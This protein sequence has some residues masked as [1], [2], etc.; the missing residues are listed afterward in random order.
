MRSSS[1]VRAPGQELRFGISKN[2]Y[3]VALF[4]A[5]AAT[6]AVVAGVSAIY[7]PYDPWVVASPTFP[8]QLWLDAWVRWDSGW[9]RQ[10]AENGYFNIPGQQ[11][12]V[13]FF[14]AYPMLMRAGAFLWGSPVA[15]GIA[16]TV[17]SGLG[18]AIL[19]FR[20][21]RDRLDRQSARIALL[22]L[23]LWPF[24]FYLFGAVY[25]DALFLF[26][27][28]GAFVLLE[29]DRTVLA[30]LAAAVATATRPIGLAV[31]AGLWIRALERRGVP[32]EGRRAPTAGLKSLRPRDAGLLLSPLG[33]LFYSG[34]LWWRFGNPLAF[35]AG[36]G[37]PGW[38]QPLGPATWLKFTFFKVLSESPLLGPTQLRLLVHAGLTFVALSLVPL[39]FRRFGLGYGWYALLVLLIPAISSKDFVGMGRYALAAFPCFV[40]AGEI[41]ASR[42]VLRTAVLGVSATGLVLI[43]SRFARWYYVA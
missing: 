21:C 35:A 33:F 36:S 27:T 43:T 29:R 17:L 38:D 14:P 42:P 2:W 18:S 13:A 24:A 1:G 34:Y 37:A 30:G 12:S 9:Y 5:V 7:L 10:I 20:W 25:S 4:L 31:V 32:G 40:V 26:A 39:V 23:M 15:A 22:L 11:S 28:I 41:L 16:I 19:F 3:P 8:Q 6:L